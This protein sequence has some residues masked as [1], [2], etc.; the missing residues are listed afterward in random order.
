[1]P[2]LVLVGN[3]PGTPQA[4]D[5]LRVVDELADGGDAVDL[6]LVQDAVLLARRNGSE[7][8]LPNVTYHVLE[9]ELQLRGV[10]PDELHRGVRLISDADLVRVMLDGAR[11]VIGIL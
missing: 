3:A 6:V 5:A 11:R 4:R 1:M 10:R 7:P 2:T 9:T 8:L